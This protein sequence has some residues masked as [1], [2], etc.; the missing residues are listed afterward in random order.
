MVESPNQTPNEHFR[1]PEELQI[2]MSFLFLF[3]L[4]SQI[5]ISIW[6]VW[7]KVKHSWKLP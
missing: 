3:S 4:E 7:A 5:F 1:D 2:R 6:F